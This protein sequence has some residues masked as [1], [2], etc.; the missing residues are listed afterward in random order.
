[1]NGGWNYTPSM[2]QWQTQNSI[3]MIIN[4]MAAPPSQEASHHL[5]CDARQFTTRTDLF[6]LEYSKWCNQKNKK[7]VRTV[8]ILFLQM[9][10]FRTLYHSSLLVVV[11]YSM[12]LFCVICRFLFMEVLW[13]LSCQGLYGW[14]GKSKTGHVATGIVL[15]QT[16]TIQS[17]N[18]WKLLARSFTDASTFREA[19]LI[20][21]QNYICWQQNIAFCSAFTQTGARSS[22]S[23]G[24]HYFWQEF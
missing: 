15:V 5:T 19:E 1:M 18:S 21:C 8:Q 9:Q 4:P 10:N 7:C 13:A 24:R 6:S 16:K 3:T 20:Y 23:L 11:V 2:A 12:F 14:S 17:P 22:R